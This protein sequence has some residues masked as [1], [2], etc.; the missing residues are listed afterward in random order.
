MC[1]YIKK[2]KIFNLKKYCT[3]LSS[4]KLVLNKMSLAYVTMDND[5][6]TKTIIN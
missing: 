5:F 4:F 2:S 1:E 3:K 6:S